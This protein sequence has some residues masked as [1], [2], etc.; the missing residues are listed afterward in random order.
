MNTITEEIRSYSLSKEAVVKMADLFN[1]GKT[2]MV[3]YLPI[4]TIEKYSKMPFNDAL[5]CLNRHCLK[6]YLVLL[7]IQGGSTDSGA[8]YV[9]D[10]Q[11]LKAFITDNKI[12]FDQYKIFKPADFIFKIEKAFYESEHPKLYKLI[13]QAF[14]DKRFENIFDKYNTS[15]AGRENFS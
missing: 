9:W 8:V 12:T 3:G 5:Y 13:G 11:V 1:V 14:S 7:L 4:S 6:N 10:E 2:K 15:N